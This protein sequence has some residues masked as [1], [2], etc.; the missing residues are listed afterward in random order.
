V[1]EPPVP[2]LARD[3]WKRF[4]LATGVVVALTATASATAG[5]LEVGKIATNFRQT[6]KPN[7][8]HELTA[9]DAGSPQTIMIL[10]SD[11]RST[12]AAG[13]G[14]SDTIMLVRLDPD[15]AA[16]SLLS[17]PRDLKVTIN[18]PARKGGV[19]TAKINAAYAIGGPRLALATVKHVL[20]QPGQ[21]PFQ[22]NH[23]VNVHFGGFRRLVDYFG[24]IYVD[25]DRRYFNDN[26]GGGETYAQIDI[27]PGYQKLCGYDALAYVRFRHED[28]DLVR[29]ARQQDFLRTA[30]DQIGSQ[31]L[32]D[33]REPLTRIFGRYTETDIRNT[34]DFL[35]LFKLVAFS[36][37][38]PVREVHFHTTLGPSYVTSTPEQIR[39]TVN[40]FLNARSTPGPRGTLAPTN[41]ERTAA[42]RRR[43][44]PSVPGGLENAKS[45]GETGAIAVAPKVPFP[46]YY[47]KLRTLGGQYSD[48]PH[49]YVLR[50]HRNRK[51]PAYR[52][53]LKKGLVGEYY[54]VQGIVWKHAPILAHPSETRVIRGRKFELFKDGNRIRLVALRTPRAVYWVSNTLLLSLSNT[55]MLAFAG[56]LTPLGR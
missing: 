22:I 43:R 31:V 12:D 11:H 2:R 3:M 56:S 6:A 30:K 46:V 47:P 21:P 20:Q 5:L 28:N 45:E 4:A 23:V 34:V 27:Q 25:V 19:Q 42:A 16:T 29:A 50:D 51:H 24:C 36:A 8:G 49:T 9:A 52:M 32:V 41:A 17:I 35:R 53:V 37:G 13:P 44:R 40:E 18:A 26:S 38:H 39:T 7:T 55:Q 10:G 33:R 54:G 1:N 15:K 48:L 14:N